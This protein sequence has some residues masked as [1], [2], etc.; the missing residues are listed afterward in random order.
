MERETGSFRVAITPI[1]PA[2]EK[3]RLVDIAQQ[4]LKAEQADF[5][6]RLNASLFYALT[7]QAPIGVYVVDDRFRLTQVNAYARPA[8]EKVEAPL[9]RDFSE[10]MQILWGPEL[11]SQIAAIFRH[12]LATGERYVTPRFSEHRR[13]LAEDK[14][15]QWEIQRVTL[16][17]GRYGVVCYFSDITERVRFEKA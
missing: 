12:T 3:A 16:P 8:F 11:G 2:T 14:S 1:R 4:R 13:D 6:L 17:S 15:Y 7:E 10:V 9:G 5:N